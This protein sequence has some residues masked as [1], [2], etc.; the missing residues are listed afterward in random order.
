VR[1][2][3]YTSGRLWLFATLTFATMLACNL[4][5]AP[6]TP[7][8][9]VSPTSSVKPTVSILSP[10]NNTDVLIGQP[11]VVQAR[12]SHPDGVTRLEL[13]ANS[14]QVDSKVSQNPQG[15]LEFTANLNFTPQIP[16]LLV[17]QVFAYH[18]NLASDPAS[19]TVN[20]KTQQA[21][22]TAT[23]DINP[24]STAFS[25]SDPT[26]R[27]RVEVNGLNFRQGP[28]QTFPPLQVLGIGTIVNITGR[29]PD[30]SWWQGRINNTTG[31]MS[32]PFITLLGIC[33]NIPVVQPPAS[34]TPL[35]TSTVPPT[36]LQAT[37][38][39]G[40][41]DLIVTDLSGPVS[42]ILDQN[43][44]KTATYHITVQNVGTVSAGQFNVAVVLP[45]GTQRVLGAAPGLAPN[46][47]AQAQTDV[48]FNAPGSA[49]LTAIVDPDNS[50]DE[51]NEGNNLK[52]LDV[53]LIKPT[54][55]PI[56]GTPPTSTP[57]SILPT[58]TVT[59]SGV[60]VVPGGVTP[61]KP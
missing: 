59:Q 46:Q 33:T 39:P 26:C 35:A 37:A 28:G 44:T 29:L 54:P 57:T 24:G 61:P 40:K 52:S 14:Q 49:R 16:G 43:G 20:V 30:N 51:A 19:V 42:I 9:R 56:T 2:R 25:T 17:L 34:P 11:I 6:I 23:I 10:Q 31:W 53:V 22:V 5:V 50:V 7:T 38:T 36:A 60:T 18:D 32:K 13:R 12:G 45:D 48:T 27:A 55:L 8:P 47:F 15:D 41:P 1:G 3:R 21:Q 58:A 4:G